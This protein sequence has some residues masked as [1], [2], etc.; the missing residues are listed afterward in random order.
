MLNELMVKHF[1]NIV[2]KILR[3]VACLVSI[4]LA[5]MIFVNICMGKDWKIMFHI[6]NSCYLEGGQYLRLSLFKH[7]NNV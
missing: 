6:V 3:C 5:V 7:S 1:L 4:T 2:L